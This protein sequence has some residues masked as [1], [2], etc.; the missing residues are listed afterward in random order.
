[1]LLR[2]LRK[3]RNLRKPQLPLNDVAMDIRVPDPGAQLVQ[4]DG[5]VTLCSSHRTMPCGRRCGVMAKGGCWTVDGPSPASIVVAFLDAGRDER[6][7][8]CMDTRGHD[9]H[10]GAG[11]GTG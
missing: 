4:L 5:M 3:L 10:G 1:M 8:A 6:D 2:E 9:V 7:D 11:W